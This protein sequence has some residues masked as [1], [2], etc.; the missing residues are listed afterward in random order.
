MLSADPTRAQG[1]FLRWVRAVAPACVEHAQQDEARE[2]DMLT[3]QGFSPFRIAR[4]DRMQDAMVI[5]M[6][7]RDDSIILPNEDAIR[8]QR[9]I[10]ALADEIAEKRVSRLL[11]Q[12]F[13]KL[14]IHG[15]IGREIRRVES[16]LGENAIALGKAGLQPG[17]DGCI[18]SVSG[19]KAAGQRF[20]PGAHLES[21]AYFHLR[22]STHGITPVRLVDQQPLIGKL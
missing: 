8:S 17:K 1:R 18:Q 15:A 12:R 19:A 10:M 4:F 11:D 13:M 9:H 16:A 3:H 7:A 21:G 20:E 22:K 5:I 2:H 14:D 6:R